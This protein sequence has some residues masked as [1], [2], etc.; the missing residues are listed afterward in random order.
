MAK[1]NSG[2]E[3]LRRGR[4]GVYIWWCLGLGALFRNIMPSSRRLARWTGYH[5]VLYHSL[6]NFHIKNNWSPRMRFKGAELTLRR[7]GPRHQ[8]ALECSIWR[9]IAEIWTRQHQ[10]DK[11]DIIIFFSI[12]IFSAV[13]ISRSLRVKTWFPKN[14]IFQVI[15]T[16]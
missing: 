6:L 10:R 4:D 2:C 12:N 5:F 11:K 1:K 14:A 8:N 13:N 16:T 3:I 7:P 9:D 15:Y